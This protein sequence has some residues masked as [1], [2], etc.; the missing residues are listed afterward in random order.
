MMFVYLVLENLRENMKILL[1][2][3]TKKEGRNVKYYEII[4]FISGTNQEFS[5]M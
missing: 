3:K 1:V 2:F 5:R 4:N